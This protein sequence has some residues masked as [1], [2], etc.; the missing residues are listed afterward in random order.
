MKPKLGRPKVPKSEKR[1]ILMQFKVNPEEA[2]MVRAAIAKSPGSK[3][4]WMRNA[5]LAAAN[6]SKA[7]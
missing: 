4:E 6:E 1:A 2:K 7:A 5:V 3:S